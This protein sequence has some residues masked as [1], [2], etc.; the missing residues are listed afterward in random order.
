MKFLKAQTSDEWLLSAVTPFASLV[1]SLVALGVSWSIL[2]NQNEH[3]A[4]DRVSSHLPGNSG[5]GPALEFLSRQGVELQYI[6]LTPIRIA[7]AQESGSADTVNGADEE[8]VN[9]VYARG[10]I[11][12]KEDLTGAWL[13]NTDF[14]DGEFTETDFSDVLAAYTVFTNADLTGAILENAMIKDARFTNA[15]LTGAT[16]EGATIDHADF[17]GAL[18]SSAA[19]VNAMIEDATF[20]SADLTG[21]T[22][23]G[24]TIDHAYFEWA[25]LSSAAFVNAMIEDATF[26]SADLT[27]AILE[28]A[29]IRDGKFIAAKLRGADLTGVEASGLTATAANFSGAV[30]NGAELYEMIGRSASFENVDFADAI[31][32][33]GQFDAATFEDAKFDKA[34][35]YAA[36]FTNA[37]VSGADFTNAKGFNTV[38]LDGAWAWT[39]NPPKVPKG[40]RQVTLYPAECR[41]GWDARVSNELAFAENSNRIVKFGLYRPPDNQDCKPQSSQ[42]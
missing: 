37:N 22:L 1:I 26:T 19:F 14:T 42:P 15:D 39:D 23:E 12:S 3:F 11:L 28:G 18:L 24:A 4:W 29:V 32:T 30:L 17:E 6:D 16:L 35:L 20:T 41:E 31:L 5:V 2:S 38:T 8:D 10:T 21:A 9:K 25:L 33:E 34:R 36:S 7:N 27:D 13:T 40:G